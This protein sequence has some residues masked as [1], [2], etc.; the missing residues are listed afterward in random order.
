MSRVA[1]RTG[2]SNRSLCGTVRLSGVVAVLAPQQSPLLGLVSVLA[3]S[4]ADCNTAVVV[5][6]KARHGGGEHQRSTGTEL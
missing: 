4:V 1:A 3:P 2:T 6:S 5:T